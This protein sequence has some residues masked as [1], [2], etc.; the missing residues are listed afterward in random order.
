MSTAAATGAG[1][2]EDEKETALS[3]LHCATDD[4]LATLDLDDGRVVEV[5][6]DRFTRDVIYTSLGGILYVLTAP[7]A[8]TVGCLSLSLSLPT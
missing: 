8:H 3:A 1:L 4:D 7:R 6:G 2:A 5:L